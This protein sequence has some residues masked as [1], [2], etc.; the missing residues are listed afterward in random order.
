MTTTGTEQAVVHS[1]F[2]VEKSYPKPREVVFAAFADPAKK[3]RWWAPEA[4]FEVKEFT[5]DF[6]T[7]GGERLVYQFGE[8]T[9]LPGKTITNEGIYQDIVG[10]ERIVTAHRMLL[11]GE[12]IMAS[13][14][15]IELLKTDRG[16]DLICTHQ[17]AYLAWPG[18]PEMLEQGWRNLLE[19]L[20][21]AI[22]AEA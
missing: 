4:G 12:R 8:G 13:L 7:G 15:T 6:R 18:G 10:N 20:G 16:T 9:P 19:R 3:R 22:A 17:G 11:D 5:M 21:S 1:T 14:V 2:V